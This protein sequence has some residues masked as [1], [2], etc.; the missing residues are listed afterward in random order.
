[1]FSVTV[2][3]QLPIVCFCFKVPSLTEEMLIPLYPN[4]R[5]GEL[6]PKRESENVPSQEDTILNKTKICKSRNEELRQN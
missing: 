2:S 4:S 3:L 1:M 6:K 5:D